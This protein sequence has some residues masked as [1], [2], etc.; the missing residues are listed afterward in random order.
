MYYLVQ[1]DGL[2]NDRISKGDVLMVDRK[3]NAQHNDIVLA[4]INSRKLVRRLKVRPDNKI[5]LVTSNG[6]YEEVICDKTAVIGVVTAN[7]M[8]L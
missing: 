3:R 5:L 8:F 7:I 4:R 2:I 1:D 6:K